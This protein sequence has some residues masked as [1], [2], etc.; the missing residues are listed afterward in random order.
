[1]AKKRKVKKVSIRALEVNEVALPCRNC[2]CG[3]EF[4]P[5]LAERIA[6]GVAVKLGHQNESTGKFMC[7]VK[8]CQVDPDRPRFCTFRTQLMKRQ[9]WKVVDLTK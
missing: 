8:H 7:S 5:T 9:Q 4:G 3:E 1:M 6:A 2:P